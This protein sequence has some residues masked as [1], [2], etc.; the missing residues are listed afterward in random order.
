MK[1]FTL[2]PRVDLR[3]LIVFILSLFFQ[4]V[5]AQFSPVYTTTI[6]SQSNTDFTNNSID[7]NLSTRARVRASSGIALNIGNYS[8]HLELQYPTQIPANTTTYIK[9]QTDD[10]LLPALLSGSLGNLVA[11]VLGV[12]LIGNQEFS[13]QA[14]NQNTVVL[15]GNSQFFND[16]SGPR[17]RVV[18]NGNNEYFIAITPNQVYDR[19]R[20]TNR[21]GALLGLFNTKRLDV[22]EAFYIGTP[23]AC[24]GASFTSFDGAGL[25]LD[26]L[27][28]GQAGVSNPHHVLDANQ[29][30]FSRLSLGVVAV[31]SSVQQTVYFGSPSQTTDDFYIKMRID[32]ALLALGVANNIQIIASNG[33]NTVQTINLNSLLNLDLLTLLQSNQVATIRYSPNAPVSRITIR[34]NSLLNVQL[35]QSLDLYSINRAPALPII[36]DP[37]TQNA[38]ACSGSTA[39]LIAT[40]DAGNELRWYG[41]P[42]GGS[43]LATTTSGAP[44]VTP[45][46]NQN[47]A[48]YV[49]AK[50]IGCPEESARIRVNVAVSNLPTATDILIPDTVTACN[51]SVILSP[52]SSIGGATF[53][54]YKDQQKTQEITSGFN[55][56]PGVTY[57]KND[58]TGTLTI[59]GLSEA[60][61]PYSYYI[62]IVNNNCENEANTLKLVTVNYSSALT[63]QVQNAISGCGSVNLRDAILNFNGSADIQYNFT[64]ASNNPISA[65][66]ASEITTSGVYSIQAV[67]LSGSCESAVAQVTVTVN[68]NPTLTIANS[69]LVANLGT[70]VTLDAVSDG[71]IIW[72]DANGTAISGNTV[73]PFTDTGFYTFTA[74]ASNANCSI[75]ASVTVAVIDPQNCPPLSERVYADMQ[76]WSSILTGGVANAGNAI[77]GNPQTYS[78][79]VTGLGLLGIGTTWQTLQWEETISAG[80]PVTLKL[81]SEYSGVVVAGAYSVIGT[82]RNAQGIPIDIGVI[83]PVSGSLVDLLRAQNTIDYTLV[84]SNHTGQNE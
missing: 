13:V 37:A 49:A 72:Y 77:D 20:L 66:T 80:T 62:S 19:V 61:S 54:Y 5:K 55:G 70:A 32:P 6:S 26:L 81:G 79:I 57:T 67:S 31:A 82:K 27:N 45:A 4:N 60:N 2:Q 69:N 14:K 71:T 1:I 30:N 48:F 46:L 43:I 63:L 17:L 83:Q 8:G 18:A 56:D 47:T 23:D 64:D 73:G 7:G 59:T 78:T 3:Y 9:I 16:F 65:E 39:S 35:T 58:T 22:F 44:F 33:P 50:R 75:S 74:V 28:L 34:Y 76:N 21:V 42:Q 11:D 24:G 36:T 12:V 41:Q 15:E 52:S 84:P 29:N 25:N 68:P 40:I 53:K 10:N 51:G 38:T